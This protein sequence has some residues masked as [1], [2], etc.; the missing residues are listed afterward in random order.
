M[1]WSFL[2]KGKFN[3]VYRNAEGTLVFKIQIKSNG[4]LDSPQRSVRLWNQINHDLEPK[5]K[6]FSSGKH[7]GWISPFIKGNRSTQSEII[8]TIIDIYNRCGRVVLDAI[9]PANFITLDNGKVVCI[10]I[11]MALQLQKKQD[12]LGIENWSFA[13]VADWNRNFQK[14]YLPWFNT[15]CKSTTSPYQQVA[16]TTKALFVMQLYFPH[17]INVDF[18]KEPQYTGL[19]KALA[20]ELDQPGSFKKNKK[21]MFALRNIHPCGLK[22]EEPEYKIFLKTKFQEFIESLPVAYSGKFASPLIIQIHRN[23]IMTKKRIEYAYDFLEELLKADDLD[24][25]LTIITDTLIAPENEKLL[26]KGDKALQSCMIEC[27]G[28]LGTIAQSFRSQH[29]APGRR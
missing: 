15:Y 23:Q 6:V 3:H 1:T 27:G 7:V 20:D 5:A 11:G 16:E 18:L 24:E 9:V 29:I 22:T 28:A 4:L 14:R 21:Q 26:T 12:E 25:A 19:R 13:S 10:D 17:Y 2:G 8:N